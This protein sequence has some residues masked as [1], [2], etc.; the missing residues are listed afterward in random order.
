MDAESDG[1]DDADNQLLKLCRQSTKTLQKQ[2]SEGVGR[3]SRASDLVLGSML[4]GWVAPNPF[5][6]LKKRIASL[7]KPNKTPSMHTNP[8]MDQSIPPV[9]CFQ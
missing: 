8:G 9:T 4:N 5:I 2:N 6:I 7:S 3:Y 1:D